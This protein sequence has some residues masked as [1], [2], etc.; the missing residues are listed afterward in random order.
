MD[1]KVTVLD[2]LRKKR[3]KEKIVMITAYD[4]ISAKLVDQA[5]VDAILVGDSLGMLILGY[6]STLPVTMEEMIHHVK[7]V[8]RAKPKALIIGDMPFL[9]YEA[10]KREAVVNAG[11]MVKAGAEA[12]KVEGGVEIA[13]KIKAIVEAGIPVMGHV[14]LT[15]QRML[16]IG[17]YKLRGKDVETAEKIIEDAKAVEEAGA[18]SVVLEYT[19]EEVAEEISKIL[20]IPVIGIGSGSKCDGQVLVF[21]DVLGLTP[22]LP[23]FAKAYASLSRVIVDSVKKYVEEVKSGVFPGKEHTRHMKA[24]EVEEFKKILSRLLSRL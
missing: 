1:E 3:R 8:A 9:S 5:G 7:A 15:P 16:V 10:G 2:I 17:G 22:K 23:P 4:Y 14:G 18:F 6:P 12:V 24:E 21:H 19:T 11:R 20:K 13:D